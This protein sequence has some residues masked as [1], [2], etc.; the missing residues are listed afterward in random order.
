MDKLE[1]LELQQE[2]IKERAK[3]LKEAIKKE[4]QKKKA[5]ER[6]ALNH[7]KM[8]F[9]EE[10]YFYRKT[11]AENEG[12][13]TPNYEDLLRWAKD[14]SAQELE[15]KALAEGNNKKEEKSKVDF[16][17]DDFLSQ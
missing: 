14:W 9:A 15:K 5:E 2:E 13:K 7:L 11:K 10:Y 6:K 16:N 12:K 1:K 3:R 4:K 8:K 17:M